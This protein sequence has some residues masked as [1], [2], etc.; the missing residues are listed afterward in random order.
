[1][2]N[3]KKTKLILKII[4]AVLLAI[5]ALSGRCNS[6]AESEGH[7][8]YTPDPNASWSDYINDHPLPTNQPYEYE[9]P[10][11]SPTPAPPLIMGTNPYTTAR[12][13]AYRFAPEVEDGEVTYYYQKLI[14]NYNLY[15]SYQGNYSTGATQNNGWYQWNAAGVPNGHFQVNEQCGIINLVDTYICCWWNVYFS[16]SQ[17]VNSGLD[18]GTEVTIFTQWP[19]DIMDYQTQQL[20]A[21]IPVTCVVYVWLDNGE[22]VTLDPIII[23][24]NDLTR[25]H[26]VTVK[27]NFENRKIYRISP[28]YYVGLS[29]EAYQNLGEPNTRDVARTYLV[30]N[31]YLEQPFIC[32]A[33]VTKNPSWVIGEKILNFIKTIPN[34]I[35]DGISSL[36]IP[37]EQQVVNWVNNHVNDQPEADSPANRYWQVYLAIL[38]MFV[39]PQYNNDYV[40]NVPTW[41]FNINGVKYTVFNG[42][43]F[44]LNSADIPLGDGTTL[45]YWSRLCGS[46]FIVSQV[47]G[48]MLYGIFIEIYHAF[49][50]SSKSYEPDEFEEFNRKHPV[51]K[52]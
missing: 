1:M 27:S 22:W 33:Y 13:T 26:T 41:S 4:I 29:Y 12:F 49:D 5:I 11:P 23:G 14:P 43:Q 36:I 45:F 15:T 35:I 19:L 34:A 9:T 2:D 51:A 37:N 24:S 52:E 3:S 16:A 8:M 46:I 50:S 6:K 28:Y 42:Y 25:G 44:H 17:T 7:Y 38:Q 48:N 10:E 39:S 20:V 47:V 32:H 31:N 40:I 30:Q 18:Y 21:S